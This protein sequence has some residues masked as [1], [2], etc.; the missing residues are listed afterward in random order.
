MR[1]SPKNNCGCQMIQYRDENGV[2]S[3]VAQ[4]EAQA[5]HQQIFNDYPQNTS[6]PA[7]NPQQPT[8]VCPAHA[9]LGET[10]ALMTALQDE[11]KKAMTVLRV[12]LGMESIKDLGLEQNKV[13]KDG[14][15]ALELKDGVE[16]KYS[17]EGKDANRTLKAEVKGATLTTKQKEDI[18]ALC[19]TKFGT[20]KV[21]VL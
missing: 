9:G 20:D 7:T 16:Y 11:C 21:E 3:F 14:S 5:L 19:D 10:P 17:F 1:W 15:T 6:N 2:V 18:K 4:A 8:V 13:N 12:L